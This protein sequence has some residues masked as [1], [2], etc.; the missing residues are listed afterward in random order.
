MKINETHRNKQKLYRMR[1]WVSELGRNERREEERVCVFVSME[2]IPIENWTNP[3]WNFE[4][5]VKWVSL[6]CK[7]AGMLY[8]NQFLWL[9]PLA[10]TLSNMDDTHKHDKYLFHYVIQL[11]I[12]WFSPRY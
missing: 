6:N 3:L 2:F 5:E 1:N 7:D 8:P 11:H 9:F 4:L 10:C 12:R